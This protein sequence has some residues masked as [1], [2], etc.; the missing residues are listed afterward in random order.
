MKSKLLTLVALLLE[1]TACTCTDK[2]GATKTLEDAGYTEI[3]AGGHV[4]L[5]C[6]NDD[7]YATHFTAKGPSGHQVEGVVCAAAFKGSTIRTF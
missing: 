7:S 4:F 1:L 5:G 3:E 2:A 6:G